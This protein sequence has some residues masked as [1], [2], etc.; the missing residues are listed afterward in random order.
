MFPFFKNPFRSKMNK[1]RYYADKFI[2]ARQVRSAYAIR[3]MANG[4]NLADIRDQ[5]GHSSIAVTN[6][7]LRSL[8]ADRRKRHD[9]YTPR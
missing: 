1:N 6:I 5:L 4:G 3:T 7:Y 2:E 8:E 9:E